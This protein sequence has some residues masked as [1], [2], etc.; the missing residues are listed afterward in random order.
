MWNDPDLLWKIASATTAVA[1]IA[2]GARVTWESSHYRG[3]LLVVTR[4]ARPL[5]PHSDFPGV[6]TAYQDRPLRRPHTF[7]LEL[8]NAG[9]R[10][11]KREDFEDHP[12]EMD[13]GAPL[14]TFVDHN[15]SI[16]GIA[17]VVKITATALHFQ[18]ALVKRAARFRYSVLTDDLPQRP[19]IRELLANVDVRN[20]D[21]PVFRRLR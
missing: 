19:T 7:E 8:I 15:T 10:D 9:R 5:L 13:F 6:T 18:P 16:A 3:R 1:A 2:I 21:A 17:P 12:L 20:A 4:P 11:I 14:I